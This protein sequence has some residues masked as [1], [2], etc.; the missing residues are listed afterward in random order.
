MKCGLKKLKQNKALGIDSLTIEILKCS[1]YNLLNELKR[2]FNL[3]LDSGY[4]PEK[5]NHGMMH[6]IYKSGPKND[7]SN[8]REITLTSCL[9]KFFSTL[10]HVRIENG[11]EE[12]KLVAQLR[13]SFRKNY[14]TPD[15]VMTLFTLIKKSLKEGK[16][17]YA[18]FVDFRK[19]Y[20]SICRHRLIY[21]LKEFGLN[22][23]EIIKT[24]YATPKVSLLY[25]GKISQS[26]STKIGPK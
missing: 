10:L 14:R 4:Y 18:C 24:M 11:V 19:A 1:N 25:E 17:L 12:K 15:H 23:L 13:A 26:F 16:Y 6:T 7:P 22:K 2:L 9:E 21:E 8:Y 5:W 3:A 20:N